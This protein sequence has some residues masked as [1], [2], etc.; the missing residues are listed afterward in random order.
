MANYQSIE[1]IRKLR[2]QIRVKIK[3]LDLKNFKDQTFGPENEYSYKGLIAGIDSLLTDLSTLTQYENKFL[4][5]SDYQDRVDIA[6]KLS[7]IFGYLDTPNNLYPHVDGLK[8]ILR[9]YNVR[10][11]SENLIQFEQEIDDVRKIKLELQELFSESKAIKEDIVE[12]SEE[13]EGIQNETQDSLNLAKSKFE[14]IETQLESFKEK[15]GEQSELNEQLD[16]IKTEAEEYL[17][18]ILEFKTES[19]ANKKLIDAFATK[20]QERETKLVE[21]EERTSK[22]IESLK[23]YEEERKLVLQ[24]ANQLIESAKQALNYKTAEGLSDAFYTQHTDAKKWWKL[25]LWVVG[26]SFS[27]VGTLCLGIWIMNNIDEKWFMIMG[28]VLLLPIPIAGAVF[29]ANQYTKQKNIIEDYAYKLTIAKAIVGFSEQ[30]KKNGN[31]ED[32]KEYTD[33]IQKALTEI[34]KDPLRPRKEDS[35]ISFKPNQ[36]EQLVELAKKIIEISKTSS[37]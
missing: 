22:N 19:E 29:C 33:Y 5:L 31:Q 18:E 16:T 20:V 15:T 30:L 17:G 35:S 34:H 26:A 6:T 13:I 7:N 23:Q 36:L 25:T 14:E 24:Q 28:R 4:K 11:L 21:L 32:Q 10:C 9:S 12:T 27:L 37:S 2:D 8:K 3:D 1:N